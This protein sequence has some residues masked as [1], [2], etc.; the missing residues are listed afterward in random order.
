MKVGFRIKVAI[1]FCDNV[2]EIGNE[3][4]GTKLSVFHV[5]RFL[6][7]HRFLRDVNLF[8]FRLT[9]Y[10]LYAAVSVGLQVRN[11]VL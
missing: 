2:V 5:A 1:Y 10:S 6:V 3:I 11:S 7:E 8:V 9:A 4:S